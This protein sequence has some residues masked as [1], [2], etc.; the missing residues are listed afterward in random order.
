MAKIKSYN[1]WIKLIS[2][3]IL[4]IRI[5]LTQFGFSVDT[6]V[7][8][9]IVTLVAGILILLGIIK[10]PT[11]LKNENK[12]SISMNNEKIK[13]DILNE[14]NNCMSNESVSGNVLFALNKVKS[15]ILSEEV[16]EE[17]KESEGENLITVNEVNAV[18]GEGATS[19]ENVVDGAD[20]LNEQNTQ[21][22]EFNNNDTIGEFGN[23]LTE[24]ASE[25]EQ[26]EKVN[27]EFN[28][29]QPLEVVVDAQENELTKS[30][31]E[32]INEKIE[33][34]NNVNDVVINEDKLAGDLG[35]AEKC[36]D[37][38]LVATISEGADSEKEILKN[39][40]KEFINNNLD[41]LIA[42]F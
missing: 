21:A 17:G 29:E 36:L 34:I 2:L 27:E 30:F 12:E 28:G 31:D 6:T 4:V 7:I 25:G 39:K 24:Q 33:E 32:Q 15:L 35:E 22:L 14:L 20:L 13:E 41:E 5:I 8:V 11:G 1:F 9:D 40:I 16:A 26:V 37:Q 3:I 42:T 10:E 18:E 23:N 38:E 19:A